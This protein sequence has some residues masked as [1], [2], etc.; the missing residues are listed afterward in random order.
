M[1]RHHLRPVLM[2]DIEANLHNK[3]LGELTMETVEQINAL[4]PEQYGTRK[5]KAADIQA[6]N[7]RIFTY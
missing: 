5:A 1:G 3:H 4:T 7:T 6:L 2:F